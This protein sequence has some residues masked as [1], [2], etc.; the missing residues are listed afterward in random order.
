MAAEMAI[1]E[2]EHVETEEESSADRGRRL[3]EIVVRGILNPTGK[4]TILLD[5]FQEEWY[6]VEACW[7]EAEACWASLTDAQRAR[8][9]VLIEKVVDLKCLGM[10]EGTVDLAIVVKG[11]DIEDGLVVVRDWK[12]GVGYVPKARYNLQLAAYAFGVVKEYGIDGQADI[13]I[14]QPAVTLVANTWKASKADVEA[15]E[16]RIKHIVSQCEKP[17]API[18]P[19]PWCGYCRAKNSCQSRLMVCAEVKQIADPVAVIKAMLPSQRVELYEKLS[20][21]IKM[22]ENAKEQIDAG[23]IENTIGVPG[24]GPGPGKKGRFWKA[25]KAEC[26]TQLQNLALAKGL[27]GLDVLD[28][29]SVSAAEKLLGKKEVADMFGTKD[30]NPTVKRIGKEK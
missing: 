12:C 9:T 16:G 5:A 27:N 8:A 2:K 25:E 29:I 20:A 21:A 28:P 11:T 3:H 1:P 10:D 13:G 14:L 19:G 17:D 7:K 6:I 18:I 23:I 30:G 24:Y 22:L 4:N 26:I 15:I